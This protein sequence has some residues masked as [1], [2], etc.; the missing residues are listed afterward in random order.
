MTRG[1]EARLRKLEAATDQRRPPKRV[2]TIIA[3]SDAEEQEKF[4]ELRAQG[5]DVDGDDVVRIVW[6]VVDPPQRDALLTR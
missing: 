4:D 1:V 6:R 2:F 5:H 3:E